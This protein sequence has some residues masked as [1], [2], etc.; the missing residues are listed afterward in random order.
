MRWPNSKS[1]QYFSPGA[2]QGLAAD[3][4]SRCFPKD[5]NLSAPLKPGVMW[6]RLMLGMTKKNLLLILLIIAVA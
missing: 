5:Q 2:E 6:L 1:W 4:Q 3:A